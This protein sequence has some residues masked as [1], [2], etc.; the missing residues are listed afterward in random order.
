MRS[1]PDGQRQQLLTRALQDSVGTTIVNTAENPEALG[2]QQL[3]GCV[4]SGPSPGREAPG[5]QLVVFRVLPENQGPR[6]LCPEVP[7]R[8]QQAEA[9]A[10]PGGTE[11]LS[12]SRSYSLPGG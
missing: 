9:A 11:G 1:S 7:T 2:A 3:T 5:P 6:G 8:A 4:G 12:Q 10:G